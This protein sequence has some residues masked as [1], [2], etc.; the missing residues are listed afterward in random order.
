MRIDNIRKVTV[1]FFPQFY[2]PDLQLA[3]SRQQ[4]AAFDS[5]VGST[6][7]GEKDEKMF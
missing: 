1:N 5:Q 2:S 6:S 7:W 4:L 3:T